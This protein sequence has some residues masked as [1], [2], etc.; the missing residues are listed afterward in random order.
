M[1]HFN[2]EPKAGLQDFIIIMH[3]QVLYLIERVLA[4]KIFIALSERA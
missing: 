1:C 3:T 2:N 4:I